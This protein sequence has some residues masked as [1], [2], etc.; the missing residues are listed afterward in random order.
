MNRTYWLL[1]G[2]AL[3]ARILP[4]MVRFV[5][6]SDEGLFLTLG[7]NLATGL[8][9]TGDG[10]TAQVDFPPGY[11]LFAAMVYRL[12][13]GLELPSRLNLLVFGGLLPLPVYWLARQLSDNSTSLGA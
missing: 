11:P 5:I 6:G 9:Y 8:G 2:V 3:A 7:Q 10:T 4:V 12:R 13:G 1:A